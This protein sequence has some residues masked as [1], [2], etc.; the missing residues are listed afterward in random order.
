MPPKKKRRAPAV[1]SGIAR[2]HLIDNFATLPSAGDA[3][4]VI[5]VFM[6]L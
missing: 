4:Y 6:L 3:L 1:K 5:N 2:Q